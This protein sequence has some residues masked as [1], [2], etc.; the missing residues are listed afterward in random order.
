MQ[1][2]VYVAILIAMYVLMRIAR[3]SPRGPMPAAAE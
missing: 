2:L 1:L 3:P